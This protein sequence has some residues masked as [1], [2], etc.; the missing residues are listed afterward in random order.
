MFFITIIF[1][2]PIIGI[3]LYGHWFK[4]INL[5]FESM[6]RLIPVISGSLEQ[7]KISA[8][9]KILTD[10]QWEFVEKDVHPSKEDKYLTNYKITKKGL[11][12][13]AIEGGLVIY[14][15]RES[16]RAEFEEM[17]SNFWAKKGEHINGYRY[18]LTSMRREPNGSDP[19]GGS[20]LKGEAAIYNGADVVLYIHVKTIDDNLTAVTKDIQMLIDKVSDTLYSFL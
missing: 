6:S 16:A 5:N 20:T 11:E 17:G 1:S 15:D 4:S 7:P 18:Y 8:L 2:L 3:L 13:G 12:Y 14:K 9:E 19:F 10:N